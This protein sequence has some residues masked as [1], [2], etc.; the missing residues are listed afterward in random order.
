[1]A[2]K[3]K[4]EKSVHIKNKRATFEFQ[5][6]DKYVAGMVLKGTEIKS[7][8]QSK[9]NMSDSYCYVTEEGIFIKNLHI[10]AYEKGTYLNHEPLRDRKLLLTKKEIKKITKSLDDQG[11]T[12]IPLS[13]YTSE[14]GF[15][16]MEIAIAKGKKLYDKR[17]DIKEKDIK[18]EMNREMV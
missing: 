11:I 15:A 3:E 9:V 12:L 2:E 16:K 13:I 5:I 10:S 17:A 6:I 8:R 1:M 7:I 14:R 4:I 18:R